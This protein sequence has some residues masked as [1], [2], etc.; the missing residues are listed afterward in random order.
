MDRRDFVKTLG[1]IGTS[2]LPGK[3][4]YAEKSSN[5][6]EFCG[7]LVDTTRCVGC[8]SCTEAC[9]EVNNLPE[10]NEYNLEI[11]AQ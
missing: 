7:I 4:L 9:T 5:D 6:K 2:S 1:I 3:S 10:P 8:Q 11:V